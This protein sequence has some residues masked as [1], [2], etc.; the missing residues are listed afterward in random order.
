MSEMLS[1]RAQS[2]WYPVVFRASL[3]YYM[4]M[5]GFISLSRFCPTIWSLEIV[6]CELMEIFEIWKTNFEFVEMSADQREYRNEPK[7]WDILL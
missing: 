1:L 4:S 2:G 6:I 3:A 5:N 7:P